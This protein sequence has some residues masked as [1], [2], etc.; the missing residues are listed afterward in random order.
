MKKEKQEQKKIKFRWLRR[1]ARV[2]LFFILLFILLILFIRS[3]WGQSIIVN[4]VTS[5]VS[6]KTK[7]KVAINRLF[8]TFSGNVFLDGLYLEDQKGDTL[9][10]SKSLEVDVPLWPVIRG[11]A[12]GLNLV[13]WEGLKVNVYKKDSIEGFNFQ[14]LID[15]FASEETDKEPESSPMA[16]YIKDIYFSDFNL[17]YNDEVTGIDIHLKLG[18]LN[19]EIKEM[20][21]KT[22]NFHISKAEILNTDLQFFQSQ[23]LTESEKTE[24]TASPV[25]IVDEFLIKNFTANFQSIPKGINTV[26]AIG[27]LTINLPIADMSENNIDINYFGL[28]NS[29]INL[30]MTAMEDKQTAEEEVLNSENT[31]EFKW[32]DWTVDLAKI[33]FTNNDIRYSLN[34]AEPKPGKFN[35]EAI[36]LNDF[37]FVADGIYLKDQRFGI[38]LSNLKFEEESG[39]NLTKLTFKALVDEN[40]SN[41]SN[42]KTQ[43]NKNNINTSFAIQYKSLSELINKPENAKLNLNINKFD[44]DLNDLFRFQPELKS[45]E[46]LFALSKKKINGNVVANGKLSSIEIP[47]TKIN[48]GQTTQIQA[49]GKIKNVT[50]VDNLRLNF[51]TFNFETVRNDILVFV[52]EKEIGIPVPERISLKSNFKGALDDFNAVV[53]LTIPEGQIDLKAS[54]SD[55]GEIAYS[56]DVLV[57]KLQL[58]KLLKNE[59]LGELNLSLKSTGKGSDINSL[60]ANFETNIQSF[61]FNDY[62]IKDLKIAGAIENG[63]GAIGSAYK[64]KNLDVVLESFIQLDS[65]SSRFVVDLILE[66][67][68]LRALGAT[69]KDIRSAFVLHADFKGNTDNFTLTSDI[70][71]GL[72]IVDNQSYLLGDVNINIFVQPDTTS[73]DITNKMLGLKLR[74]NAGP[75][76]FSEALQRYFQKYLSDTATIETTEHFEKDSIL[77]PVELKLDARFNNAPILEDVFIDRLQQLDTIDIR[78][79]FSGINQSLSAN[80]F[81][82]HI[83]YAGNVVDSLALNLLS[84][85]ENFDFDF[86]FQGLT[87]GPVAISKTALKGSIADKKLFLD[88]NSFYKDEKIVQVNSEI[89]RQNDIIRFH[90]N[91]SE[92]IL[93]KKEWSIPHENDIVYTENHL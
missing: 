65:M 62:D 50:D 40:Q 60:D 88:I 87:A 17:K 83:D 7:T 45:N 72:A 20:D 1:I 15:A 9:A 80:I 78:V 73:V 55:K 86:G 44:V 4:K 16:F 48:W 29:T 2:L 25:L 43:L 31:F 10:S 19:L 64:D 81:M 24:G 92:L 26:A 13:E 91:P 28:H 6:D 14:F 46:T 93:N 27:E 61:A 37:Y 41:F 68:D 90:I 23:D 54:F 36:V 75:E 21:L 12:I 8:I 82:P 52:N 5:Y 70:K 33:N 77:K 76:N 59:Q 49:S 85:S 34:D 30:Q 63:E 67:A 18:R 71:D 3:P 11:N 39:L 56:A 57:K 35:P 69:D 22:M 42:L 84:D 38:N 47:N 66:G 58:N 53:A 32:P 79:D 89:T 74:S 51:P